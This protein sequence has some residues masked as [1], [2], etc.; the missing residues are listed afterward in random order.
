MFVQPFIALTKKKNECYKTVMNDFIGWYDL[1]NK[2]GQAVM[3]SNQYWSNCWKILNVT[4]STVI[5]VLS[6]PTEIDYTNCMGL[7]MISVIL[8]HLLRLTGTNNC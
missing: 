8:S 4:V 7:Y 3:Y 1:L 2:K 6:I 5:I